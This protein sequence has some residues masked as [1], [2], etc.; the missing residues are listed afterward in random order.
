VIPYRREYLR[1][2][3]FLFDLLALC[4][5]YLAAIAIALVLI[6][7]ASSGQ[8]WVLIYRYRGL[9]AKTR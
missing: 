8:H 3:E 5:S 4:N 6:A 2:A 1:G 9:A 7:R